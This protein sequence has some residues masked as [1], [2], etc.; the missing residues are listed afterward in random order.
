MPDYTP[1]QI[2]YLKTPYLEDYRAVE[3]LKKYGD[4]WLVRQPFGA[5]ISVYEDDLSDD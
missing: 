3:L 1:G 5:V 4:E 2:V